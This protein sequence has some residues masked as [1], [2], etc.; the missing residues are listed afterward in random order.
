M[1]LAGMVKNQA[2]AFD[3][4]TKHFKIRESCSDSPDCQSPLCL[5]SG[6][7]MMVDDG[8]RWMMALDVCVKADRK[9]Q[10]M[11]ELVQPKCPHEVYHPGSRLMCNDGTKVSNWDCSGHGGRVRCPGTLPFMC[12]N[13]NCNGDHCCATSCNGNG[14]GGL[15]PCEANSAD[16]E[17]VGGTL[18]AA[19]LEECQLPDVC[20]N[21]VANTIR[22][23]QGGH[24]PRKACAHAWS[25]G[26]EVST[27]ML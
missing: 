3:E 15:R 1:P 5:S 27:T 10:W 14:Y 24:P 12:K 11:V 25:H 4:Y 18:E 21:A 26:S 16:P 2:W 19:G 8:T 7:P 9:Q 6:P 13:E 20:I 17:T 22:W 23:Y